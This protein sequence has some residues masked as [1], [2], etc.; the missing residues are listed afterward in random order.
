MTAPVPLLHR[1]RHASQ[2]PPPTPSTGPSSRPS[3]GLRLRLVGAPP[4]DPP[5]DD[6]LPG[7]PVLRLVPPLPGVPA[8]ALPAIPRPAP[9]GRTVTL[10]LAPAHRPA[11]SFRPC[12]T[13]LPHSHPFAHALVLRLLEVSAGVRPA[14]QLRADTTGELFE[15][16]TRAL[17]ARPRATGAR[18]TRRDVRSVHVQDR[19]DGV[20]EV[21]ATVLRAGRPGALALRL[22]GRLGH[23][24]CTELV[25]I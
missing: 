4:T 16:L 10:G 8:R 11:G 1:D 20:A 25:G 12:P 2:A 18:P 23:W 6:E 21:C 22:E 5:Y 9:A 3:T 24:V 15:Q 19:F 13:G 7:S 17:E 14:S